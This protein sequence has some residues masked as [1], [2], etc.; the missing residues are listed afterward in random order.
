MSLDLSAYCG[1]FGGFRIRQASPADLPQILNV[2]SCYNMHCVPG[3]DKAEPLV[4]ELFFL[5]ELPAGELAGAAGFMPEGSGRGRTTLL[6]VDPQYGGRG[7]GNALQSARL[8]AM[9]DLGI[10]TVTTNCDRQASIDWYVKHFGYVQTGQQK[11]K[12]G[13]FGSEWPHYETLELNLASWRPDP[14][15]LPAGPQSAG[16][17]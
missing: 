9:Q 2:M 10:E 4:P 17:E 3:P 5:A 8:R 1:S 14:R 11:Q 12:K 13:P 15:W 7:T 16:Q 6:S